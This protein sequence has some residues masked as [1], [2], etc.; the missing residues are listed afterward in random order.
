[1]L[2]LVLTGCA[3]L[4]DQDGKRFVAQDTSRTIDL[5]T[6]PA[7]CDAHAIAEDKVGTRFDT[8]VTILSDPAVT[9]MI[10]LAADDAAKSALFDYVTRHCGNQG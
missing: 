4:Q 3:G 8:S 9:G 7:R 1:M 6:I 10:T 2:V 5:R